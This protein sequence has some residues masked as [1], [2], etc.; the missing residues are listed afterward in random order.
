MQTMVL[1]LIAA[2]DFGTVGVQP[3][4]LKLDASRTT[5]VVLDATTKVEANDFADVLRDEFVL[6]F[7]ITPVVE[8][9]TPQGEQPSEARQPKA[10]TPPLPQKEESYT[11]SAKNG[12]LRIVAADAAGAKY[13][14]RTLF[15]LSV[16][17]R[18]VLKTDGFLIPECEVED[19]PALT[20]RGVH[21]CWFPERS[22]FE[23]TRAVYLAALF[24]FNYVVLE[25]WGV[26]RSEK[27]PWYGWPNG[28]MTPDAVRRIA[29]VAKKLGLTLVPQL[30]VYGHASLCRRDSGKHAALDLHPEY[31]PLFEPAGGWNWCLTNP[32]TFRVQ[33][34]LADE[35]WELCDKPPYFHIGCDEA[36]KAKCPECRA[37]G[38]AELFNRVVS[39]HADRFAA[40]GVKMMMWHDM[41]IKKGDER[42]KGFSA[43]GSDGTAEFAE[44][45]PKNV[46]VCDWF[47]G[48]AQ[49]RY[50]TI[51]HFQFLGL[52][53][54]TCAW[55]DSAGTLAQGKYAREH[56]LFGFLGT[57]W[58]SPMRDIGV[59]AAAAWGSKVSATAS[60]QDNWRKCG[61]L[62]GM[63]DYNEAGFMGKQVEE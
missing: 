37:V 6:W 40:R 24:K 51:E 20:W 41:L 49:E 50:P 4:P 62:A 22:E 18:G 12:K 48:K 13:A 45:L 59:A 54:M 43:N 42:W 52:D 28:T 38:D 32:E 61:Q 27:H 7:G 2:L 11:L 36:E 53:V 10:T 9:A 29:A 16:P 23:M 8:A 39:F 30:N 21:L 63:K 5:A 56:K 60:L 14:V 15:Q 26:F 3:L 46:I 25:S 1:A 58:A 44:R 55:K 33:A 31:A 34:E 47:Y 35:L 19:C 57:T 17:K